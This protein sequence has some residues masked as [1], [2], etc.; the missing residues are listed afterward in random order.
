MLWI[1]GFD[2]GDSLYYI[3]FFMNKNYKL[4]EKFCLKVVESR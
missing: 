4:W 1:F 3:K 2:N